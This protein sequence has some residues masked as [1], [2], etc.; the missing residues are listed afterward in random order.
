MYAS[1]I[2]IIPPLQLRPMGYF[3]YISYRFIVIQTS[4]GTKKQLGHFIPWELRVHKT[5][6]I[7]TINKSW[8]WVS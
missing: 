5:T 1:G 2:G 7:K 6:K 8:K 3:L 4:C